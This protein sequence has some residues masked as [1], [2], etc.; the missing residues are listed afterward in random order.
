[1]K[2]VYNLVIDA[3][4]ILNSVVDEKGDCVDPTLDAL[5]EYFGVDRSEIE[6]WINENPDSRYRVLQKQLSYSE[7]QPFNERMNQEA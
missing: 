7:V 5:E 4:V 1:M 6:D 3:Y 2:K